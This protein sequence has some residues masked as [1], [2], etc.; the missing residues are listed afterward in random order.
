MHTK[1]TANILEP[2][3]QVR[4]YIYIYIYKDTKVCELTQ[5]EEE[6]GSVVTD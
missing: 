2:G 6:N 1:P 4:I 5:I 3:C